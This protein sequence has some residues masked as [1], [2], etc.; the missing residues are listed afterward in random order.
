MFLIDRIAPSVQSFRSV[1]SRYVYLHST[2]LLSA[3][4]TRERLRR[5]HQ[6]ATYCPYMSLTVCWTATNMRLLPLNPA[7][8]ATRMRSAS[9]NNNWPRRKK[10]QG[11]FWKENTPTIDGWWKG[12]AEEGRKEGRVGRQALMIKGRWTAQCL[13]G[14]LRCTGKYSTTSFERQTW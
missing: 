6:A 11:K 8:L 1:G 3:S 4:C 13:S 12:T 9:R 2:A 5:Q 10:R 7:A 14:R